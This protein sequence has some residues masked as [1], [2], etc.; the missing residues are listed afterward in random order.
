MKSELG[1]TLC[2]VA[3]LGV[4]VA[5]F[6]SRGVI[7]FDHSAQRSGDGFVWKEVSYVAAS[8][9]YNEGK[10]IA[11][12]YDGWQINEVK[13]D[14]S[15]T[16]L[17]LRSF[18]DQYL[19]VRKDYEIPT[20]GTLNAVFIDREKVEDA[21]LCKAVSAIIGNFRS[22]FTYETE[23]MVSGSEVGKMHNI[24]FCFEDCPVGIDPDD[25][26]I[27]MLA[28]EWVLAQIAPYS[29]KEHGELRTYDIYR[30]PQEYIEILEK[31]CGAS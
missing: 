14:E 17:V 26:H 23:S 11:K 21:E 3:L 27:G 28:G 16:F 10:T 2:L 6:A 1:R 13:E 22:D 15:H 20:S 24:S 7:I 9:E 5:F 19:C 25:S 8:A 18:N 30:I 31:Y 29:I 12:T 4:V